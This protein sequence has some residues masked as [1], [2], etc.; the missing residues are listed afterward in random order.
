MIEKVTGATYASLTKDF[1]WPIPERFNIGTACST[2]QDQDA[3][4]LIEVDSEQTR[5]YSFGDLT[6][7]SDRLAGGLH[8]LGVSRGDRIAVM[9]PQGLACGIAH[10]AIYKLGAIAIPLTQLFGPQALGYR[11]GDSGTTVVI[12]GPSSLD[13]VTEVTR[14]LDGVDIVVAGGEPA[15]EH[16]SMETLISEAPADFEAEMTGPDDPAL[17]IYTSGTTGAPKG[18]LHAHRVLLGHLPGFELMFDYFPQEGD[19][20]WT[21]ADWAWIGGLYDVLMPAWFHGR[22]VIATPKARFEPEA[23]L[24]LMA[25]HEVTATF[26]P[27]TALKM[28][29]QATLPDL[30]H[31]LRV[32][33]SGGEPLGGEML[34][35]SRERFG[36]DIN[37][38]Y[39]QTE[40]NLLVGNSSAIWDV[41]PGSMGRPYPG[42]RVAVL[43]PSGELAAPGVVGEIVLRSDD[44]VVMLEYWN[45]PEATEGKFVTV[46][47]EEGQSQRWLC[48]GDLGS[49]DEDG[50]FWFSSR[51]DDVITSA[52]YRIGPAEIE[53]CVLGHP[54]VAMVAAVGIPDEVRG[55]VVKVFVKLAGSYSASDELADEI[56]A[57]VRSRLAAY[58]YPREV[59]FIDE[60]PMTTTGKVRRGELKN[61]TSS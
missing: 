55:Q 42:H 43:D 35:W 20:I 44:P 39:G 15:G 50:Y 52:G 6:E 36:V 4:A 1:R 31:S 23:A 54:A 14:D 49:V 16:V 28:M 17:I 51:E 41:R 32:I 22:P 5:T 18:A 9:L 30:P 47:D 12:T 45:N 3:L 58:E 48:T 13:L 40:A 8:R 56:R 7:Q 60:L 61:R 59:E 53:E 19:R 2:A 34:A 27:P 29:R 24:R 46:V 21:P 25:E 26:L 33:M 38:I 37:E 11:L 57:H 10:L